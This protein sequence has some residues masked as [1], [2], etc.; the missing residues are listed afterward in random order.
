METPA[1]RTPEEDMTRH[2]ASS[3]E[4][5]LDTT[6]AERGEKAATVMKSSGKE[7][8]SPAVKHLIKQAMRFLHPDRPAEHKKGEEAVLD[9][10]LEAPGKATTLSSVQEGLPIAPQE[11]RVT[12]Q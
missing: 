10:P 11:Q 7:P 12:T 1:L 4:A 9:V 8:Q 3:E 2:S 5:V 6:L